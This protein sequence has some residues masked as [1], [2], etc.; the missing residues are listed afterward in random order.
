MT[1]LVG[2]GHQRREESLRLRGLTPLIIVDYFVLA[3]P[4]SGLLGRGNLL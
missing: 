2:K 3:L 4:I 1:V